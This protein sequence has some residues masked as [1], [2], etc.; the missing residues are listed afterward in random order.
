MLGAGASGANTSLKRSVLWN[1]VY[2]GSEVELRGA[3]LCDRV[4]VKDRCAVFEGAVVGTDSTVGQRAIV[5]PGV[6]VWPDKIVSP[7]TTLSSSVIWGSTSFSRL[8]GTLGVSG[9]F[10]IE[11]TAGFSAKLGAAARQACEGAAVVIGADGSKVLK[12]SSAHCLQE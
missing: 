2:L 10:N 7:G 11:V 3:I 6:K 4:S 1:N 9:G 5:K 8:F 12:S